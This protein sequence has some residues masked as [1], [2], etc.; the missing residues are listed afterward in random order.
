VKRHDSATR[1]TPAVALAAALLATAAVSAQEKQL[2]PPDEPGPFRVGVTTFPAVMSGGR[3]T[4]IQVYYPTLDAADCQ[5]RYTVATPAGPYQIESP[6]GAVQDARAA[7]GFFPLVVHDHGGGGA[8]ADFQRI[9]QLPLHE[10][11]AS[12]GFVVAVALHSANAVARVRDLPLVIDVLLARGAAAGD[13]LFR[14]IDPTR[15]GISG[16]STGGGAAI[17]AAG[18]WAANGL[19]AD[20]RIKA[21]LVYE[22][23]LQA[24]LADAS[25]VTIPYLVMGGLQ[26]RSGLAVPALF[27]ATV[28]ATPRIYVLTPGAAHFNYLTGL[29]AE[30]DQTREAALLADP[31]LPEPLT[32]RTAANAAAAR[33]YDLWNQGEILF[34]ALG[35]GAGGG[36][37]ICDRVGVS[38]ARSL[39]TAPRDGFT[40]SPPFLLD[41]PFLRQPAIPEEIMVPLVKLYTVAFW[42]TCLEGDRRYM[43]YLTPGYANRNGLGVTVFR[44]E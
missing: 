20:A 14:S 5:T 13:L 6:L 16:H 24:S 21:M 35:L 41:D 1:F 42:K 25:T 7:P 15:I 37:N 36:R 33:A 3:A 11:M 31:T 38:S 2:A 30:I 43:P 44:G 27:D 26:Y 32:T 12:H 19:V 29:G 39:D 34:P 9:S 18:G 40:D 10:L 4:Q 17:G 23:T 22:P 8:G 28:L